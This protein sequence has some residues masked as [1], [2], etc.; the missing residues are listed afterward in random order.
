MRNTTAELIAI[1]VLDTNGYKKKAFGYF[2]VTKE[3]THWIN[4][5]DDGAFQMYAYWSED[6]EFDKIYDTGII[7]EAGRIDLQFLITLFTS[8]H[9]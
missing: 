2:K 1:A 6:P 4:F 5:F 8:N 7:R 3:N 9:D